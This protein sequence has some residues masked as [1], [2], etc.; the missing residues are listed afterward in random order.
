MAANPFFTEVNVAQSQRKLT[1]SDKILMLGSCFTDEIGN[2]FA[3]HGF[4]THRNPFGTIYNPVSLAHLITKAADKELFTSSEVIQSG[5]F[6]YLFSAHGDIRGTTAGECLQ[7]ANTTLL[8]TAEY[9]R[10][11]TVIILTFGT[12][13]SYWYKPNNLLMANC[14]KIPQQLILR[15]MFSVGEIE[16][17]LHDMICC[18]QEKI[19]PQ[20]NFIFTV[21]PVR[22]IK[23]GMRD[24]NLSK[25]ALHLAVQSIVEREKNCQYFPS[26]EIVTDELRDYRFYAKDM[27]HLSETAVD[28][29]WQKFYESYF[30]VKECLLND[31]Y[32]KLFQMKSHRPFNP[33]S[34][35][36]QKHLLKIQE[37]EKELQQIH[38]AR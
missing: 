4:D 18:V 34:D 29:V 12:A 3:I 17:S 32:F 27:V 8:Q 21:S 6:Y 23:E 31:N 1:H 38:S 9:L 19:N 16:R 24:N 33:S 25:S 13:W 26:Y 35:G 14:H 30:D 15:R 37:L 20:I 22:H 36:Y 10:Q 2:K 7:N 28:Y 5:E 11:A